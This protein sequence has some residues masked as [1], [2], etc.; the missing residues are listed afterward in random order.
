MD[1]KSL[2]V[3]KTNCPDDANLHLSISSPQPS[4]QSCRL[5]VLHPLGTRVSDIIPGPLWYCQT[6][7]HVCTIFCY[8]LL[9]VHRSIP[10]DF[11]L[12]FLSLA[13]RPPPWT[14]VHRSGRMAQVDSSWS[15]GI[16]LENAPGWGISRARDRAGHCCTDYALLL[17]K[18]YPFLFIKSK[19]CS[20][21]SSS[22]AV[23]DHPDGF[24]FECMYVC[25]SCGWRI[26]A[27]YANFS[28]RI[29]PLRPAVSEL[30]LKRLSK[31]VF[32]CVCILERYRLYF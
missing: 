9:F 6:Y 17:S 4:S 14:P 19:H 26:L 15:S 31:C 18:I 8:I 24:R 3:A 11:V 32:E 27:G 16:S 12:F 7:L 21:S 13:V 25:F 5:S 30:K 23:V 10:I 29:I 2:P 22:D 20:D 1:W 28:A